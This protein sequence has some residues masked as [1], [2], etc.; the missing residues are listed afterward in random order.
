MDRQLYDF[1]DAGIKDI[2]IL[3]GHLGEKIEQRY[4]KSSMGMNFHYQEEYRSSGVG[5][6]L[7]NAFEKMCRNM[8]ILSVRLEVKTDNARA[9]KFYRDMNYS[10]TATLPA[11]YSDGSD[12][13]VM[14]KGLF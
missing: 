10:N 7:M 14:W 8:N 11:Y 12:A 4:G 3:S 2:Y 13:Y 9:I 5:G 1:Q 6:R